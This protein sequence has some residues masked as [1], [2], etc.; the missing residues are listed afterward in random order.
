[1]RLG[2]PSPKPA[3]MAAG[4]YLWSLEDVPVAERSHSA[5]P[6]VTKQPFLGRHCLPQ[7]GDRPRKGGLKKAQ[8]QP[9]SGRLPRL[10]R[11]SITRSKQRR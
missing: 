11:H 5:D 6:S 4:G 3:R 10:Q 9:S 2:A 7:S 8:L 1:M